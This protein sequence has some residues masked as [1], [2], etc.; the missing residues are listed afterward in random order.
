[1]RPGLHEILSCAKQ[2]ADL[3]ER[4]GAKWSFSSSGSRSYIGTSQIQRLSKKD[5]R[6]GSFRVSFYPKSS[7]LPSGAKVSSD[8]WMIP[9]TALPLDLHAAFLEALKSHKEAMGLE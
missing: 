5:L 4:Y 7:V 3:C 8:I 6:N 2:L 1:M 9:T